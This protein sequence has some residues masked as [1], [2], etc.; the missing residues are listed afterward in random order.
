MKIICVGRNYAEHAKEL[1]NDVP[2]SPVIFMKPKSALL[3]PEKPLYYPE[4]TDDLQYECELVVRINKNGKFIQEKFAKKYYSEVSLG[5][6][7][8]ARDLQRD[9]QKKGLPWEIAKAFDGSAAVGNFVNLTPE[10]EI[11]KM[12]FQLKLNDET[13]QDGKTSDMIFHVDKIIAYVSRFFALNIGDLVFTG[14]PSGVGP[15][16]GG[17]KLEGYL[18]GNKVLTVE[19][20]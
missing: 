19:V 18:E 2:T 6:D 11:Q 8:T 16:N 3:L 4:F 13:V 14:T 7:F 5:I 1:N 15:V 10:M 20:K 9:L 17:D 12:N